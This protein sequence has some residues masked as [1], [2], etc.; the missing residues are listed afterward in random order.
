MNTSSIQEHI[1]V[2]NHPVDLEPPQEKLYNITKNADAATAR[3]D[4]VH[5][6]YTH[7]EGQFP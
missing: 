2:I 6:M 1:N 7:Q 4:N 5:A 3:K